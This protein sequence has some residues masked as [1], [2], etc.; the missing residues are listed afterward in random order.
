MSEADRCRQAGRRRVP[1]ELSYD[2]DGPIVVVGGANDPAT[3]IRW[4][5]EMTAASSG[6]NARM[7]TYTGEG[8][9]QLL[10][11]TCVTDIEGA[12]LADLT[13]PEADTVCEPDPVVDEPDW[14][15]AL[16]VPDGDL[17]RGRP[18]CSG[19]GAGSYAHPAVQRDARP[20]R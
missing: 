17:R 9:G 4:A 12:L 14:W 8:H 13:L 16:P 11:S 15:D 20:R 10:V 1:I 6:S 5:Q 2:G 3:P 18:A 19:G 7:V